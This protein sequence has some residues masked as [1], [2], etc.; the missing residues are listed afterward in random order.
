MSEIEM[1]T[2]VWPDLDLPNPA[3]LRVAWDRLEVA[4]AAERANSS[5]PAAAPRWPH[6]GHQRRIALLGIG[7]AGTAVAAAAAVLVATVG[8][9]H[10]TGPG[11][12]SGPPWTAAYVIR[13]AEQALAS[14]ERA[15]LIEK[16][17]TVAYGAWF[18]LPLQPSPSAAAAQ[19]VNWWYRGQSRTEGRT[20]AG[21]L[22]FDTRTASSSTPH[23]I[24]ITSQTVNYTA[25]TWWRG[26]ATI[27]VP[28]GSLWPPPHPCQVASAPDPSGSPGANWAAEIRLAMSCRNYRATGT[29][30]VDGVD[31]VEMVYRYRQ[32]R[33]NKYFRLS[34]AVAQTVWVS[35]VTYLPVQVRWTWPRLHGLPDGSVTGDFTWLQ[36]TKA[37]LASLRVPV[38]AAFR[39]LPTVGLSGP[40]FTPGPDDANVVWPIN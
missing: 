26:H 7:F 39:Q 30:V 34:H 4:I 10:V 21:T 16:T 22:V 6:R 9:G 1:I 3:E 2:E 19:T 38:P 15:N 32:E 33:H 24:T 12:S 13:H 23:R 27:P 11:G 20:A 18:T 5:A 17:R 40:L 31:T 14:A 8:P 28:T 29:A 37:N 36:P 25:R 35:R